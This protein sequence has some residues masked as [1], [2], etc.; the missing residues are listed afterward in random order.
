[1]KHPVTWALS[2]SAGNDGQRD[3][4]AK[5]CLEKIIWLSS[6]PLAF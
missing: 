3:E 6:A 5:R 1:M 2:Y 4:A